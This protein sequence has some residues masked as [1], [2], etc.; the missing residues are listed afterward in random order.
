MDTGHQ[1]VFVGPPKSYFGMKELD[2]TTEPIVLTCANMCHYVTAWANIAVCPLIIF[3]FGEFSSPVD[4]SVCL[5]LRERPPP[6]IRPG[7]DKRRIVQEG[8]RASARH[9]VCIQLYTHIITCQQLTYSCG[10][11]REG[12]AP[13][14]CR[15]TNQLCF[16]TTGKRKRC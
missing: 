11:A 4:I 15:F 14:L 3:V 12:R 2:R 13:G 10:Q 5:W 6:H 7:P 16:S 8:A 1:C 9:I